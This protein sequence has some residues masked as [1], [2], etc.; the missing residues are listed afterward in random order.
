[1]TD[2]LCHYKVSGTTSEAHGTLSEAQLA[3]LPDLDL[4]LQ[5][6]LGAHC[7]SGTW[8][9]LRLAALDAA[10]Y[11]HSSPL[12]GLVSSR[13]ALLPHQLY[14]AHEVARRPAPRVLLCDEVGLGKTIE[15]GMILQQQL[16]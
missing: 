3:A 5:R 6:L 15:A 12:L 8:F 7:Q 10:A 4:P 16:F 13:S 2:G 9:S 1:E 14:I 11:I